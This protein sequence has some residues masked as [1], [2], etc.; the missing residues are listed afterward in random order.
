[1]FE[2]LNTP[3]ELLNYKL[4]SALKMENTV[5]GML[6]ANAKVAHDEELKQLFR[7]HQDETRQ[8]IDNLNQAF[9]ACGWEPDDSAHLPMQAL[10]K[11]AKLDA[12]KADDSIVDAVV[13]AG[14]AETE[15][16]EIATYET[17]ILQA[18]AMGRSEV[19]N[20]LQQNLEME[21]HTLE[22]VK[23]AGERVAQ[24]TIAG[25]A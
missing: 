22:E 1:M 17:L 24:Q 3:D 7:H 25:A 10:D 16:L 9:A 18:N 12:T 4:G 6:D 23:R 14:A 5:L 2:R 8:Q 15:H 11:E 19:A 21:Q 13:V 20:L